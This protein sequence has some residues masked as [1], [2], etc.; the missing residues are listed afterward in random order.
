MLFKSLQHLIIRVFTGF[1]FLFFVLHSYCQNGV[2]I[3]TTGATANASAMLDVS[4]TSGGVLIPRMSSAQRSSITSPA[5]GLLV[6]QTDGITGFYYYNGSAWTLI[7]AASNINNITLG[8]NATTVYGSNSLSVTSSTTSFTTIPGLT[9]TI[10]VPSNSIVLISTDGGMQTNSALTNGY[11]S[12]DIAV[13]VDGTIQTNG[14]YQRII[15]ANTN[16]VT[17]V[18]AYWSESF[19][20][21]LATGSHTIT[22]RAVYAS[23]SNSTVGGLN[24]TVIQ[25]ELTVTIIKQ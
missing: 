3:N 22:V 4:S 9:A 14:A 15:A 6:Y 24:T 19:A 17:G 2:A 23:G 18:F 8:Q 21:T 10:T 11:S 1:L 12:V 7:A 13:F 16:G 5:T 25:P 20:T